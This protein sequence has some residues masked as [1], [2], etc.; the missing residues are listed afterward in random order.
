LNILVTSLYSKKIVEQNYF[1]HRETHR[2]SEREIFVFQCTEI[3]QA[4]NQPNQIKS[5]QINKK[6]HTK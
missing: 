5:N 4:I 1:R 2:D 6:H 3:S